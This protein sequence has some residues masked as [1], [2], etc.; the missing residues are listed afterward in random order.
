MLS[1]FIFFNWR[2][3][4]SAEK[5]FVLE[6]SPKC[7]IFLKISLAIGGPLTTSLRRSQPVIGCFAWACLVLKNVDGSLLGDES[8][9]DKTYS[10]V[11]YFMAK[12][13]RHKQTVALTPMGFSTHPL[14]RLKA[15][16]SVYRYLYCL[17]RRAEGRR[18]GAWRAPNNILESNTMGSHIKKYSRSEFGGAEC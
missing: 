1:L 10:A 16:L 5:Y 2:A 14:Q 7:P 15:L 4:F 11:G 9:R 18:N 17:R 12:I 3:I 8:N 13:P 6:K